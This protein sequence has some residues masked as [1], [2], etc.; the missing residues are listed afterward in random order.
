MGGGALLQVVAS[1]NQDV[2][3]YSNP[4]VTYFKF[5]VRKPTPFAMED[6]DIN[7]SGAVAWD[8]KL[9]ATVP[10][11]GDLLH[12]LT[13]VA[14]LPELTTSSG[15]VSWTRH[16]GQVMIK[17]ATWSIGG[18]DI[19]QLYGIWLTIFSELTM[20]AGHEYNHNILIGNTSVLTDP[21]PTIPAYTVHV[22]LPFMFC[23]HPS[24]ALP[25]VALQFHSTIISIQIRPLSE[26][27][28]LSSGAVLASTPTLG[29]AKLLGNYIFL[30]VEERNSFAANQY[31]SVIST[32]QTS[33]YETYSNNAIKSRLSF[34]HPAKYM[35]VAVQPTAN[36][37]SRANR[38]TDFTDGTTPWLGGH[39]L[40]TMKLQLN[41]TDRQAEGSAMYYNNLVTYRHF[42]HA[43]STGIYPM[44]FSLSPTSFQPSGSLNFS[45]I[46]QAS[47][48]LRTNIPNNTSVQVHIFLV[49]FNILR[50]KSG[51]PAF[52]YAI[53][54]RKVSCSQRPGNVV[55]KPVDFPAQ[56]LHMIACAA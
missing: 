43:P 35:V 1:G 29:N 45:R 38:W 41:G 53:V 6:M 40:D 33:A 39:P 3:L 25:L 20:D 34:N 22:T 24:F 49:A 32:V 28:I 31:Q 26:L 8:Q 52:S 18:T 47:L 23:L 46:D 10:R 13:F 7:F 48:L 44:T 27:I 11:T 51:K 37:D 30:D 17:T 5:V 21:S 19:D 55:R 4:T 50:I 9:I 14:E 56:M 16:I 2:F 12:H 54:P 15:N 36:T 42:P